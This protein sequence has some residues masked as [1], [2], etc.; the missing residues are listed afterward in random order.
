MRWT[1]LDETVANKII[2]GLHKLIAEMAEDPGHPL[3]AK[4][5]EGLE[6]L[7]HD[8]QNKP[9]LREKVEAFKAE[10]L[11]NQAFQRW[12]DGLWEQSR[13]ALLRMARDPEHV[14]GGKLGEAMRQFGETLQNDRRLA[15]TINRFAR[16]TAVGAAS[17]YGDGIVRLVSDTIRGWD[18]R[19][20]TGRLENAVGRDLQY[21]RING[22]LV[23]GLV[24][25]AIHAVDT[26]L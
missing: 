8:L 14:L 19:T 13:A 25:V 5:E 17:D 23:G 3:R 12:I 18:A 22:T 15:D 21:I 10:M 2:D 24:G 1:G 20:V 6:R 16:R 9:E 26:M 11:E 4:A 7:A